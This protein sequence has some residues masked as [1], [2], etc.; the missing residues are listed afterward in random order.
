MK[1]LQSITSLGKKWFQLRQLKQENIINKDKLTR[2]QGIAKVE[3]DISRKNQV[4]V[5]QDLSQRTQEMAQNFEKETDEAA[6][7]L[8]ND[9]SEKGLKVYVICMDV[10]LNT[11][12]NIAPKIA[13]F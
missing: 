11:R 8:V 9:I 4:E 2:L 10:V 6:T 1:L 7:R 3:E 5:A 13:R 12:K